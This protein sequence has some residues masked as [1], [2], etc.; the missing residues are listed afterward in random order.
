MLI[1]GCL[2]QHFPALLVVIISQHYL[3]TG[4]SLL[5]DGFKISTANINFAHKRLSVYVSGF[6]TRI[7]LFRGSKT[8][9]VYCLGSI[10][11]IECDIFFP[12][13]ET[14]R[15]SRKRSNKKQVFLLKVLQSILIFNHLKRT[16]EIKSILTHRRRSKYT[17]S[18]LY[19]LHTPNMVLTVKMNK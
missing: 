8:I 1:L 16:I 17:S 12:S 7:K 9:W 6:T 13:G 14:M 2:S 15:L 11:F 4:Y 10:D 5:T 19:L 3:F 18:D